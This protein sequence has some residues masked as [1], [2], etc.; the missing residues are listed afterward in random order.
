MPR[1]ND[2]RDRLIDAADE[3]IYQQT[4]NSTTLAD[5]ATKAEVPLGNVYYYFKTKDDILKAVIHE[6]SARLQTQF[7]EWEQSIPNAKERLR[8]YIGYNVDSKETTAQFGCALGSLCQ[9]LGKYTGELGSL[10]AELMHRSL[11]WV[12]SQFK[13]LGKGEQAPVLAKYLIGSLQGVSLLTLTFKDPN[14]LQRQS[15]NLEQWLETA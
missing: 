9:E 14:L 1:K 8:A 10:A 6:R 4:F 13:A 5:I 15:K 12:E 2:K 3:L 7:S 11:T